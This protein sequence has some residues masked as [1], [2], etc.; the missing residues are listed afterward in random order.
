[1][2]ALQKHIR[3]EIARNKTLLD[4][5][6]KAELDVLPGSVAYTKAIEDNIRHLK[7][8]LKETNNANHR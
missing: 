8:K 3:D 5:Y 4:R 1:M 7:Q 6:H 2:T